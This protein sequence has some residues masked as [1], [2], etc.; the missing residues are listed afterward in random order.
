M[1]RLKSTVDAAIMY[2]PRSLD[3][4][5]FSR[6]SLSLSIVRLELPARLH[7]DNVNNGIILYLFCREGRLSVLL[8]SGRFSV[9]M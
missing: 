9:N 8:I 4:H 7:Y 1:I 3:V 5:H 6:F 2:F